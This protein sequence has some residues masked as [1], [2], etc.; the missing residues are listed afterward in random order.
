MAIRDDTASFF[1]LKREPDGVSLE[2]YFR[3]CV[4]QKF[5]DHGNFYS[6]C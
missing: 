4:S 5:L 3:D 6:H 1:V 2:G